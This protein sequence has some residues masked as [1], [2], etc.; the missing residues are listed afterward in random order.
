MWKEVLI[1]MLSY[2][3]PDGWC[4]NGVTPQGDVSQWACIAISDLK[5]PFQHD[6]IYCDRWD[7]SEDVLRCCT[8]A[9]T[10][11]TSTHCAVENDSLPEPTLTETWCTP[12]HNPCREWECMEGPDDGC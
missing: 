10:K 5:A 6:P 7:E 9:V 11:E 1:L 2:F 3:N 12:P 4:A 8:W